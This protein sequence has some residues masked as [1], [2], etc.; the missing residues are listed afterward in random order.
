MERSL[1]TLS[2]TGG[3]V[4]KRFMRDLLVRGLTINIWAVDG[5][6]SIGTA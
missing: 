3:W 1:A 4:L 5:F 6:A 2:S